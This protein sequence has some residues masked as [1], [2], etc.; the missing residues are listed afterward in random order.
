MSALVEARAVQNGWLAAALVSAVLGGC[1]AGLCERRAQYFSQ[2]CTGTDVT[3]SPDPGCK[4]KI[5]SCT[6]PQKAAMDAYVSC[7]EA[8]NEC[9]LQVV[10]RC[11]EAHPGGV[12]LAC[13]NR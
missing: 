4:A 10:A 11:A 3:Y 5:A 9:S 7:L 2:R 8:A 13:P 12:N 1:A 6:E